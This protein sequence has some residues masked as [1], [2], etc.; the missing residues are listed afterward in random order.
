MLRPNG[1][2]TYPATLP[3]TF[4]HET[5]YAIGNTRKVGPE[6]DVDLFAIHR[7]EELV[8]ATA[9]HPTHGMPQSFPGA[10]RLR[11]TIQARGVEADSASIVI[12]V[13]WDGAWPTNR[14]LMP[15]HCKVSLVS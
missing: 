10:V 8:L 14:N 1:N 7:G 5:S 9:F 3:L 2:D 15:N 4:R 13:D 12:E 11:L 6:V